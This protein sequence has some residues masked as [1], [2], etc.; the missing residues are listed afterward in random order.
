[1]EKK[2][3]LYPEDALIL[4]PLSGY[5]DLPYRRA[6]RSGGCRY[7]FTEMVDAAALTYARKRSEGMLLRGA[8]EEFLGVQLVGS[9]PEYLRRAVDVVNEYEFDL[10]DFN[11]GCPVP[12]V[13]KK[14]AGAELGRH[15]DAALRCF[16]ILAERSRFPVSAKIRIVSAEDPEPT[17][18]LARGLAA[19]GARA[20]TVHGRIKEAVYS[21]PV[22]F[23]QI[24]LVREALPDVQVIANGGVTG[25]EKYREIRRETGCAAV[26][27]ARGAMGNPWLFRELT[28]GGNFSGPTLEE[29]AGVV[30]SHV[31][32]M[33][34]L[35]GEESAMR[36]SRKILHDYFRG[37]GF[38][39]GIK[40]EL[41]TIAS[42][43]GFD[44]LLER[45]LASHSSGYWDR[46]AGRPDAE[47]R[48]R[49]E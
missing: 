29:W 5:T 18:E 12:K 32:G 8:E 21:G 38:P 28:E 7:A 45:A 41:S 23:R 2:S 35:Y 33:I 17:L 48:L 31:Y 15:L 27:V 19:L 22:D 16:E 4:A 43:S 26:M 46:I 11:L 37:R 30:R 44:A 47:R 25:L 14:G 13:S 40:A 3:P 24:R 42:R 39:G 34:E 9:D 10:L 1:M 36:I 20:I 6:A 49:R